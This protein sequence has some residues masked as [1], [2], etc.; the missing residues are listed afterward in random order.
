MDEFAQLKYLLL[1]DEKENILQLKKQLRHLNEEFNNPEFIVEKLTPLISSVISKSYTKDKDL[2]EKVFSPLVLELIDK[3]YQE[4]QGKVVKQIAPIITTAIKEQIRSHKDEVVEALY[5]VIGNMITRYVSKTFE[6]TLIAINNQIKHGL[7]FSNLT[8]KIRAKI[9]GI[10]E[11]ELYLKE[12]AISNVKT[13]FLI[14]KESGLVISHISN[15]KDSI[16]EP[17]MVASMLTAIRSFVNDWINKNDKFQELGTIEYGNKKILIEASGYSYLAVIIDGVVSSS[18]MA[19]SRDI[20]GDIVSNYSTEIKSY[21]GD[22]STLEI[23][24]IDSLLFKLFEKK[25]EKTKLHPLI[26]LIPFIFL[27]WII[28]IS[29]LNYQDNEIEKKVNKIINSTPYLALYKLDVQANDK[30]VYLNGVLPYNYYKESLEKKISNI[31]QIKNIK[32]E[33]QVLSPSENPKEIKDKIQYLIMALNQKE[34]V[35]INYEFS[36]PNLKLNGTVW[37]KKEFNYIKK[38]FVNIE[39]IKDINFNILVK[40]PLIQDVIYFKKNSS[41]ILIDQEY[42]LIK[43][44]NLLHKLDKNF[45]LQVIAYRDNS[46]TLK[47]N[48]ILVNNR[49]K[50]IEKYLKLHGN[51]AQ[52]IESIG[53]NDLPKDIEK[54]Y[55]G[56]GRRVIFLWKK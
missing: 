50:N 1:K 48:N 32:N 29:Y 49:A 36:F 31:I 21:N 55:P 37:S 24:K 42:K 13:V 15:E 18:V 25:T 23:D 2:L 38:Q 7:S 53:L 3:N 46:G 10:S 39:G 40:P 22:K 9:H 34:S 8:R 27:A 52:K 44:V 43:I 20:L 28:Y 51:V 26:I 6:E 54:D 5:P 4:S 45:I 47:R 56:Q 33:I 12:N 16:D 35:D 19:K 17:D 11:T 30:I 41:D 14:A